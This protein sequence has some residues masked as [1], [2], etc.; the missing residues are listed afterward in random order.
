VKIISSL[1]YQNINLL[2]RK[3]LIVMRSEERLQESY[4]KQKEVFETARKKKIYNLEVRKQ[5]IKAKLQNLETELRRVEY[6]IQEEEK[7]AFQP[8]STFQEKSKL[9]SQQSRTS[10][11]S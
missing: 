8:F 10:Q 4:N 5:Q 1:Y 9:Q 3:E 7:K 6:Q 2:S 11:I